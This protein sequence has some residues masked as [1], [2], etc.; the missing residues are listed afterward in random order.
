MSKAVA[1]LV[2][3]GVGVGAVLLLA[4]TSKAAQAPSQPFQFGQGETIQGPR[5]GWLWTVARVLNPGPV[6][7]D[8]NVFAVFVLKTPDIGQDTVTT[9]EQAAAVARNNP[10]GTLVLMY[11]QRGSDESSR[12]ILP[13]KPAGARGDEDA[14]SAARA[15]FGV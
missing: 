13:V 11:A 8:A 15:D 4:S 1:A 14:I 5:S 7:P 6:A 12:A 10:P 3:V 9:P 2:V